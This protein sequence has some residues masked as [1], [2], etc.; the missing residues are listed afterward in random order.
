MSDTNV[1][2]D[3]GFYFFD[4]PH[5]VNETSLKAFKDF[6]YLDKPI[7]LGFK[8]SLSSL[9][10]VP[11][12]ITRIEVI[13]CFSDDLD[14]V[15]VYITTI[16]DL[17]YGYTT[18]SIGPIDDVVRKA[19]SFYLEGKLIGS[20]KSRLAG[21]VSFAIS[22]NKIKFTRDR[23]AEV[24][25]FINDSKKYELVPESIKHFYH[26]PMYRIR[27]LKDFSDVKKG[28]LGGYVE[29]EENLS[30][31]GKC[32]IYDDSIVGLGSRVV[33]NAIV[34]DASTVVRYSEISNNAII[35]HGSFITQSSVVRNQSRIIDSIVSNGSYIIYKSTVNM[36]CLVIEGSIINNAVVGPNICVSNGAV[37]RFDID[38]GEDYVV[39][40][41]PAVCT[42]SISSTV[43]TRSITAS[44][45][46]D[47]WSHDTK[48]DI[49]S[50]PIVG[51]SDE[52]RTYL[53]EDKLL[54]LDDEYLKW[55]DSI[56][57]FHKNHFNIK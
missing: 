46:E 23:K 24:A 5:Y 38:S 19:I 26:R 25:L 48:E 44:T 27:A 10:N 2:F 52:V 4:K 37:I 43:Y 6:I 55:Y 45:K 28:D 15:V 35:E 51:T 8:E 34:K 29:S 32:W 49:W 40:K 1:L 33:G 39:Y 22:E 20:D 54:R 7:L 47:I 3:D 57:A 16:D 14:D 30:H 17:D 11:E 13:R 53:V 42:R 31:T 18:L 36:G 41:S 56:V 9:G 21:T 12:E 50:E